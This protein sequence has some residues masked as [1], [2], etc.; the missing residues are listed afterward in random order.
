[1]KSSQLMNANIPSKLTFQDP[2]EKSE[3]GAV[4]K[5]YN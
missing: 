4:T 2:T 5:I 3:I 1:M